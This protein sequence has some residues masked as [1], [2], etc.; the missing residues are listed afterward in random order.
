VVARGKIVA[1]RPRRETRLALPGRP[2][3]VNRRHRA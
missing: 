3:S 2:E 1:E